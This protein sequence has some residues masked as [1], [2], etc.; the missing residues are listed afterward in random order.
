[1]KIKYECDY[2]QAQFNSESDCRVHEILH[3]GGIE[4]LKYYVKY[5]ANIDI[6][7][8]CDNTY[9]VYGSERNCNYKDCNAR[10]NYKDFQ[11]ESLNDFQR[12]IRQYYD[13]A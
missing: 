1:M 10:N 12:S 13:K 4:E 7:R 5:I 8:Y 6:C 2:C 11:G 9:W 3:L